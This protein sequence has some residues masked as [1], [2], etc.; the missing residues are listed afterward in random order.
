MNDPRFK[1]FA[2]YVRRMQAMGPSKQLEPVH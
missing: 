2:G 1:D